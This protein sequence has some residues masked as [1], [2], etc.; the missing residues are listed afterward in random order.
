MDAQTKTN[1]APTDEPKVE[2]AIRGEHVEVELREDTKEA[3]NAT[4]V[5][6]NLTVKEAFQIY[7][8][9]VVWT[10]LF[11]LCIIMDGYDS[12]LMGNLYALP[13][14]QRKY[15]V[16][17]STPGK[18]NVS[19]AWQ[20]ALNMG[21]PIGRVVGGFI[22]GPIAEPFGRKKTLMGCLALLTAFIFIQFFAT[23][24]EV[25]LVGQLLCGIMW[26]I[27]SSLAPTYA[28]EVCPLRLRD[29]LTAYVNL[30]WST[31]QFISIGVLAGLSSKSSSWA[32]RI[33]F[34]IQW[35][36]P[37]LIMCFV[38][39]IPESPYWL[40]R[41][42][43]IDEAE[44][45]LRRIIR[46]TDKVD[47]KEML[48]LM[49]RTNAREEEYRTGTSYLDCF[50]GANLRRTEISAGAWAVQILCGLSLP[51]W[52]VFF[53]ELAGLPVTESFNLGVGMTALGFFGTC[54]SFF[55][56][57]RFGRRTLYLGG[58]CTLTVIMLIFGF[59]G[60]APNR[61]S[62]VYAEAALLIV[63]FY[64]YFLTVGPVAYVIFS[65]TSA[66]RL[67]GHTVAIALI[68]YSLLG[69]AYNVASPYLLNTNEANLGAKTGLVYG[70]ISVL[71]CI[72]C[73]FRLPECQGRTFEELDIMFE[74]KV[75]TRQ[76]KTYVL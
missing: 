35:I 76:F 65:E 43:K 20:T 1:M 5:E 56:I 12:S 33:P 67:R 8:M 29:L 71:A 68:A 24:I 32:Y 41:H 55:L 47:I 14:F 63:W 60:I 19:A 34:A 26:G 9:A 6:H 25:L 59:L 44:L 53:F 15:G 50:K 16:E 70:S 62:L 37:V 49:Q 48:A 74:R 51:F 28:S 30:C 2:L 18:Y 23:N 3:N 52:A 36:W 10:V 27:L 61:P 66:T 64:I 46:K 13:S 73:Y 38:Y 45:V 40:V 7:P 69:I 31:G 42:G 21:S 11:C 54:C 17:T 4:E 75:P 72:W 58:L 39:W 57:P 22:Q